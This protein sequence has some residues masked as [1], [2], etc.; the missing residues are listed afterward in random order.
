MAEVFVNGQY[1]DADK[2]QVSVFDRGFLLGDGVYEVI[3]AYQGKLFRLGGHLTRLKRSLAAVKM[4]NPYTDKEWGEVLTTLIAHNGGGNQ[5]IYLQVTRGVAPR[6]HVF[7]EGVSASV[8]AMSN[9]LHALPEYY[10]RDGVKAITLSDTR[11]QRCDIKAISLLPN[12]LLKQEAK[13][14]GADEALLIRDGYLTE[15]AASN[16]YIVMDK[17][18]YTAPQSPKILSGIT[19]DV[20]LELA[21]EK[22]LTVIES[23]VSETDL[24]AAD[25]VWISSSTKEL[26]PVTRV[27][28]QVIGTGVPGPLWRQIYDLYQQVKLQETSS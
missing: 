26:V 18:I 3:P 21:A 2:A 5:A 12:S 28:D 15:G 27:N 23:A 14:A 13:E 20:V 6:D 25:E 10:H 11:W 1:L 7:P 24:L 19:R 4:D 22:G 17:V 16:A 8:F 9:P